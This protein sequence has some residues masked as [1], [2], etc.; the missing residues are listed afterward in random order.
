VRSV[1]GPS[2]ADDARAPAEM[3]PPLRRFRLP[4]RALVVGAALLVLMLPFGIDRALGTGRVLRGVWVSGVALSGLDRTEASRAVATLGAR[5]RAA[6]LQVRVR[7]K[8]IELKPAKIGF[9]VDVGKTVEQAVAA[10]RRGHLGTQ[11]LWWMKRWFSP[12]DLSAVVT[13]DSAALDRAVVQW[14]ASAINDRPFEGGVT[15]SGGKVTP[16][17]PRRGFVVDRRAAARMVLLALANNAAWYSCRCCRSSRSCREP[18][19]MR[20]WS[21]RSVCS[22][23]RSSWWQAM[24]SDISVSAANSSEQQWERAFGTRPHPRYSCTS[25]RLAS[26]LSSS[27]SARAWNGS[28]RTPAS[29]S[30]DATASA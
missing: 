12:S 7:S 11:L 16:D 13:I 4:R 2:E 17:Y 14:E 29:P 5:L 20:P 23:A 24:G 18:A 10:G 25:I 8:L 26:T 9:R 27:P 22:P 15:V 19:S 28:P 30:I 21:A 1:P 6:P 3:T